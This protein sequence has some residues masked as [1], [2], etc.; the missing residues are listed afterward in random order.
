MKHP[1]TRAVCPRLGGR[2]LRSFGGTGIGREVTSSFSLSI[3]RLNPSA[4]K[5]ASTQLKSVETAG[6]KGSVNSNGAR[7]EIVDT[8]DVIGTKRLVPNAEGV[9][10]SRT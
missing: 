4:M 3:E 8:T 2:N 1:H 7:I 5:R 6:K 10:V 9:F